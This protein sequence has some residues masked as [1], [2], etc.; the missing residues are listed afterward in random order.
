MALPPGF[1][2]VLW[3]MALPYDSR[4]P[5]TYVSP[6]YANNDPDLPVSDLEILIYLGELVGTPTLEYVLQSSPDG[7]TWSDMPGADG[8]LTAL[9]STACNV[10]G[11]GGGTYVQLSTEVVGSVDDRISYRALA[12]LFTTA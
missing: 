11:I 6:A 3:T 4:G 5:G 7:V 9:G 8:A 2:V 10:S 12:L 1:Q